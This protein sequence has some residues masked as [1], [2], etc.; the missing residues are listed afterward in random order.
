MRQKTSYSVWLEMLMRHSV[1]LKLI[2]LS[3]SEDFEVLRIA[4]DAY[5]ALGGPTIDH[6]E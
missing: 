3:A 6:T 2:I 4:R 5:D 1:C